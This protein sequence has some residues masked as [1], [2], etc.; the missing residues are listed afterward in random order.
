[1]YALLRLKKNGTIPEPLYYRLRSSGG[2]IPFLYGLPK[3]GTPLRPIVSS[4]T[5]ALSKHLAQ[6]LSPMVGNSSSFVPEFVL[7]SKSITIPEKYELVS[8]DVVSLFGLT[9]G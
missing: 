6:A 8:F 3:P 5:Y 4:L 9:S 2:H 1:M 7:F